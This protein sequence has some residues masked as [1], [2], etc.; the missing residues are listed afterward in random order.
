MAGGNVNGVAALGTVWQFLIVIHTHTP[1]LQPSHSTPRYLPKTTE[2][3]CPQKDLQMFTVALVIIAKDSK[4]SESP[5]QESKQ[6]MIF[7]HS[8]LYNGIVF[9]N[10][11]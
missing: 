6:V 9:S 7:I 5:S 8:Y 11:N 3:I 2:N 4:Q 1:A 10:T